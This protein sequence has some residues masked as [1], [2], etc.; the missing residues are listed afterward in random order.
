MAVGAA[1]A[2]RSLSFELEEVGRGVAWL[3]MDLSVTFGAPSQVMVSVY[4]RRPS[5]ASS[6]R[7]LQILDVSK[8]GVLKTWAE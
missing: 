1:T 8:C 5:R 2:A 4:V 6:A 7:A 3:E